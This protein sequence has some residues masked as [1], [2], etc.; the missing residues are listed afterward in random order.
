MIRT[1]AAPVTL[2]SLPKILARIRRQNL[3][4]AND[5]EECGLWRERSKLVHALTALPPYVTIELQQ[6]VRAVVES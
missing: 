2:T 1:N 3:D 6:F 4:A 5:V